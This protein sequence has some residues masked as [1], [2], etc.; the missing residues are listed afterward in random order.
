MRMS[1]RS[2]DVCSSD[3][4]CAG[5]LSG[6][7]G[8]AR[9]GI[10]HR[11]D[12]DTSGLIVAAKHDKAHEVLASQFAAPSID[13]RYLAPAPGRPMPARDRMS[14]LSGH[15]VYVPVDLGG[16]RIRTNKIPPLITT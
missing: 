15:S 8:G 1:D 9:P 7:G 16:S 12:K 2:S 6:I 5:Q 14:F 4:H 10:V 11:I 3:L 13:R